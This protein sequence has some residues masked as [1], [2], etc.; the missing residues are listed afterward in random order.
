[1]GEKKTGTEIM[2]QL[3]EPKFWI[4]TSVYKEASKNFTY[5]FLFK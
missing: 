3:L 4:S 2:M 1:M 5:I